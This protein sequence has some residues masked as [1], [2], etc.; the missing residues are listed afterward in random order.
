MNTQLVK[1]LVQI[2]RSLSQEERALLETELFFDSSKPS[3]QELMQLALM[4]GAFDFLYDESDIYS[5]EDGEPV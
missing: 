5:L 1:T 2:I 4:G 3:T